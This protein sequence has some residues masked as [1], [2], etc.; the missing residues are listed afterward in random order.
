MRRLQVKP[1]AYDKND[2][3]LFRSKEVS[4][5]GKRILTPIVSVDTRLLTYNDQL[6]I[7]TKGLNEIY[8]KFDSDSLKEIVFNRN[9]QEEFN[10]RIETEHNKI[11]F[12]KEMTIC[13]TEYIGSKYPL[14]RELEFILDTAYVFSDI[15]PLPNLPKITETISEES[16][17]DHYQIYL[18]EMIHFLRGNSKE[19]PIMGIVPRLAY[20]FVANLMGFYIDEGINAFYVDF[21]ARNPITFKQNLLP[22]FRTLTEHEMTDNSFIYAHN[23]DAGRFVKVSEV[24]DAKDILSFGFGFDAIGRRHKKKKMPQEYWQKLDTL[25]NKLRLFNKND[26]GYYRIVNSQKIREIYPADS[27]FSIDM[28]VRGLSENISTLRRYERLFNTEQLGLEAFRIKQIVKDSIPTRY[29]TGKRY[30]KEK[31]V[32]LMK[33][34]KDDIYKKKYEQKNLFDINS[35]L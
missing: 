15:V 13:I 34:F 12:S 23:V 2:E 27:S 33:R 19:K 1:L 20:G 31:N 25:S 35:I 4:L 6:A 16:K 14:G 30:V 21:E 8:R 3:T 10:R 22:I 24:V 9:R 26:Y 17:F 28:F 18:R 11:D 29:L 32:K 7:A 5:G